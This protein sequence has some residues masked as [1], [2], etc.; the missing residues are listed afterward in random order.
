[1]RHG[2]WAAGLAVGLAACAGA[3]AADAPAEDAPS[4]PARP[5]LAQPT[6]V[7]VVLDTV[8]ADHL[9]LCGYTRPTSPVLDAF[10]AG[11]ATAHTCRAYAPGSWTVPSHASFFTGLA[12]DV[13]GAHMV[14][15]GLDIGRGWLS[16]RPLDGA[17]PTL[18]EDMVARGYQSVLV[19]ANPVVGP[20]SGLARGFGT[21]SVAAHF[22]ALRGQDMQDRLATVLAEDVDPARPLFLVVNLTEAHDPVTNPPADHPWYTPADHPERRAMRARVRD[23][24]LWRHPDRAAA[25]RWFTDMYDVG[26]Q[27]ADATLGLV[28]GTLTETGWLAGAHRITV[29]AD[30]GEHLGGHGFFGHG[31]DTL[32]PNTRVVLVHRQVP[33]GPPALPT[34]FPGL[35]VYD[36]VRD[37]ALPDPLPPVEALALPWRE[38][39]EKLAGQT[40]VH[41][42]GA[43]WEAQ[44][45]HRT[46]GGV[47]TV[48][49]LADDP[50]EQAG[51][52]PSTA[53][54]A[55][56]AALDVRLESAAARSVELDPELVEMLQAAGYMAAD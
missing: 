49:D 21:V 56:L 38:K 55:Q 16:M 31:G 51:T 44:T 48:V 27:G 29:T 22:G 7:L 39:A 2:L 23:A 42:D 9:S 15:D 35:A 13:H 33:E 32:E 34:P 10:A 5:A 53:A 28:L 3:P 47:H 54:A 20:L 52:A 46:L 4:E 26:V 14:R 17:A 12:V 43:L 24:S 40:A 37:G 50:L 30:H 8:R 45:K 6:V 11:P 36:L 1:M 18:A 25:V 41:A 19:S